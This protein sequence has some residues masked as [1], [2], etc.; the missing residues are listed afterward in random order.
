MSTEHEWAFHEGVAWPP[1]DLVR[2]RA[3]MYPFEQVMEK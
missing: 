1:S 3:K 2:I